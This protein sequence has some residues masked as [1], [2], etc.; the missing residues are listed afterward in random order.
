VI[1]ANGGSGNPNDGGTP[2]CQNST[3]HNKTGFTAK[4]PGK[5]WVQSTFDLTPYL[6]APFQFRFHYAEGPDEECFPRTAGWYIDD[7]AIYY[8]GMCKQ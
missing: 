7:L 8:A 3:L 2:P 5:A 4:S 1:E 6:T